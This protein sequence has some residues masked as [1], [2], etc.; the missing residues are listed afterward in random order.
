MRGTAGAE[1]TATFYLKN[2]LSGG[3]TDETVVYDDANMDFRAFCSE[4][5]SP[6]IVGA[7]CSAAEQARAH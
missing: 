5:P 6:P 1:A 2:S 7:R 3:N 4:Y